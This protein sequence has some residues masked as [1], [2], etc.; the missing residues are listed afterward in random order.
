[1]TGSDEL[2]QALRQGDDSTVRALLAAQPELRGARINGA[3]V[4]LLA[5]Y[6][7]R[8][9][10]A[11]ELARNGAPVDVFVAAA[12]GI[13][14]E[15]VELLSRERGLVAHYSEDGWTPLHL[16][17]YFNQQAAAEILLAHG[18]DIHAVSVNG[19]AN[20]P[21]HAAVA[22]RAHAVVPTLL[23]HGAAVNARQHGGFTPLHSAAAAGDEELTSLL[24][25]HG[26]DLSAVTDK[27]ETALMLADINGRSGAAVLIRQHEEASRHPGLEA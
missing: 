3:P 14:G 19:L 24:L 10:L 27:G 23:A 17:S 21:L 25:A 15:L 20:Q 9:D 18:A 2:Q 4:P 11:M 13:T 12:L 26:A 8:R 1:M 7:G 5:L 16:A 6:Q 22:G